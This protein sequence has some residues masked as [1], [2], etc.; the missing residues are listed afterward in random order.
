MRSAPA[1]RIEGG[2]ERLERIGHRRMRLRDATVRGDDGGEREAVHIVNLA[3]SQRRARV[4]HFVA[5][6]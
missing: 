6:G 2:R 3:G 1:Q 5:R 4:D